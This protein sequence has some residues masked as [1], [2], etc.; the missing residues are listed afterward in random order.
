MVV[1][2]GERI[3]IGSFPDNAPPYLGYEL[4]MK[5]SDFPPLRHLVLHRVLATEQLSSFLL[6]TD[7]I[8]DLIAA[9]GRILPGRTDTVES[10]ES[11]W[12]EDRF[13]K[14]PDAMRRRLTLIGREH[15]AVA[16]D[17]KS[18]V[19]SPGFLRDDTTI[20][21]GR[22]VAHVCDLFGEPTGA[23]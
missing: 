17:G 1:V 20:V 4:P 7:G 15:V 6:A 18:L 5:A 21:T 16:T 23:P 19:R 8:D 13:F 12:Q 10:I 14:N 2:N 9:K 3:R 11:F 22:R